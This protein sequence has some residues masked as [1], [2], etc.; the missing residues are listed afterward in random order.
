[1]GRLSP[2]PVFDP[3]PAAAAP[4]TLRSIFP[5]PAQQWEDGVFDSL[6]V[7]DKD[8]PEYAAFMTTLSVVD[9]WLR[10]NFEVIPSTS[11]HHPFRRPIAVFVE[12]FIRQF[13]HAGPWEGDQ[14]RQHLANGMKLVVMD[15]SSG[16]PF[17]YCSLSRQ[18]MKKKK[19][20][21]ERT[22]Y[23]TLKDCHG[24]FGV[25]SRDTKPYPPEYLRT[26]PEYQTLTLREPLR[27]SL[28]ELFQQKEFQDFLAQ[29]G[30][31]KFEAMKTK[32][33][34]MQRDWQ[35]RGEERDQARKRLQQ[36]QEYTH[37]HRYAQPTAAAPAA[38]AQ[39]A[40][41]ARTPSP[42]RVDTR[43][44][45]HLGSVMFDEKE[46]Q[47]ELQHTKRRRLCEQAQQAQQNEQN[48]N[49]PLDLS[50]DAPAAA[51]SSSPEVPNRIR[52]SLPSHDPV[53]AR[54]Q[55]ASRLF[56][57]A[58]MVLSR[59]RQVARSE[60]QYRWT[61]PLEH[62]SADDRTAEHTSVASQRAPSIRAAIAL[63]AAAASVP[64]TP[65]AALAAIRSKRRG[66]ES[67]CTV[68]RMPPRQV[69]A[70]SSPAELESRR[71]EMQ[72]IMALPV[73]D[74]LA[75]LRSSDTEWSTRKGHFAFFQLV[76]GLDAFFAQVKTEPLNL[77]PVQ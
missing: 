19:L 20:K 74:R 16:A 63:A 62:S 77:A 70:S 61:H 21:V 17:A 18:V 5:P 75:A 8:T 45:R 22:H 41:R 12:K 25:D 76:G 28:K 42:V 38:A 57:A 26:I 43:D 54:K 73:D 60:S 55:P 3:A 52:T 53:P 71:A 37:T 36:L 72:R 9:Y 2:P 24:I 39:P 11:A 15:M 44:K 65:E 31:A 35:R 69:S 29:G 58:G 47:A 51:S 10:T 46:K 4:A 66:A 14:I 59:L 40:A 32:A 33:S 68:V 67:T 56:K 27:N 64:R 34:N 7:P 1:M 50:V 23:F 6:H 48:R 49:N 30:A 13:E